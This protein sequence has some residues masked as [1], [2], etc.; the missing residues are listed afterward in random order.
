MNQ[1]V[2]DEYAIYIHTFPNG[3]RYVGISKD[4][5]HRFRNGKG[6]YNQKIMYNAIQKYGWENVET[7][8]VSDHLAEKE[9]KQK[10]I[11][12]IALFKT[13]DRKFGYNQ[14]FGGE[15]GNGRV[16]GEENKKRTGKRMSELHKGV[17][18]SDEHKRKISETL[19]GKPKSYSE[20][21]RKRIIES[22]RTRH[23]SDQT[24][25]KMSQNTK[26]AMKEKNMSEYLS[27]KWQENKEERKAKL[28]ITMYD[29]YGVI[30]QKYDLREDVIALGLNKDDYSELFAEMEKT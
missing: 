10:E 20:S 18:L 3:K 30:P 21:G 5:N 12:Y 23:Y 22:N 1:Q 25:K 26:K 29:R 17:P 2:N 16:E 19:K 15:G 11:E 7:T 28:R 27:R 6:Y 9:A 13:T 14:T 4:V 8:I 24:R